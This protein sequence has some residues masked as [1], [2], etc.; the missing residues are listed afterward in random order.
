MHHK[1]N[2]ILF[3]QITIFFCHPVFAHF[4]YNEDSFLLKGKVI[5]QDSGIIRLYYVGYNEKS[6]QDSTKLENGNFIFSGFINEPTRCVLKGNTKSRSDD[7]P[8]SV[9]F[10]LEPGNI[11]I[12]IM[13]NNFKT[14]KITGSASQDEMEILNKEKVPVYKGRKRIFG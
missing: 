3:V 1:K 9:E 14:A 5:G 13:I 2:V 8:N 4:N 6:I 10:F 11:D 7:D 12:I